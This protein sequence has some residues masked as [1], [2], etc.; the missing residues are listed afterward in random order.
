MAI[1]LVHK[2]VSLG[3][4]WSS[5]HDIQFSLLVGQGDG[6]DHVSSQVNTQNGDSTKGQRDIRNDE[7]EEGGDLW[8]V[9]GQGVGNGLEKKLRQINY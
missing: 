9:G 5:L 7:Q 4:T 2:L 3:V 1:P 6:G 8:D